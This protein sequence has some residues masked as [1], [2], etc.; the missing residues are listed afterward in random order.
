MVGGSIFQNL[1]M[2]IGRLFCCVMLFVVIT[3]VIMVISQDYITVLK[4]HTMEKVKAF[5]ETLPE[6]QKDSEEEVNQAGAT[7]AQTAQNTP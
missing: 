1:Y 6:E 2:L 7:S 3:G 4:Q 5:A